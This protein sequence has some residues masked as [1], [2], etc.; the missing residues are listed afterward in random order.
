MPTINPRLP[1]NPGNIKMKCLIWEN[2][3]IAARV[4]QNEV[5]PLSSETLKA[6]PEYVR[7]TISSADGVQGVW[8]KEK[9][10]YHN[11]FL[12]VKD[13]KGNAQIGES[14][15]TDIQAYFD[16]SALP[17]LVPIDDETPH[18][19]WTLDGSLFWSDNVT[20]EEI[21]N[22]SDK[23]LD[24]K[25]SKWTHEVV[26]VPRNNTLGGLFHSAVNLVNNLLG[27]NS[28]TCTFPGG[29]SHV[30]TKLPDTQRFFPSQ[31]AASQAS[32][33]TSKDG[34][35]QQPKGIHWKVTKNTKLFQGE[36]FFVEFR[37]RAY[38]ADSINSKDKL[39]SKYDFLDSNVGTAGGLAGTFP[40]NAG[41]V[42]VD[43]DNQIIEESRA[44]FDFNAQPY[45]MIEMGQ[46]T[47]DHYFIILAHN[48][49]PR[50]VQVSDTV[51]V[52]AV[53]SSKGMTIAKP[54]FTCS[55]TLGIY[56]GVSSKDLMEKDVLRIQ[57]RQHLGS[58]VI[59]FSGYEGQPWVVSRHDPVIIVGRD[60]WSNDPKD[61]EE[62]PT[63]MLIAPSTI[64]LYGGNLKC[65][66]T[67]APL[68]YEQKAN[69]TLPQA[70]V[71]KGPLKKENINLRLCE[72]ATYPN[73]KD[74]KKKFVYYQDAEE[75]YETVNGKDDVKN[76]QFDVQ[77]QKVKTSGK[78]PDK[79]AAK[80]TSLANSAIYITPKTTL[81]AVGNAGAAGSLQMA[82]SFYGE[83]I[84]VAGD[85]EFPADPANGAKTKWTLKS[86]MTP[87]ATGWRLYVP[88]SKPTGMPPVVDVANHVV[89][90][91]DN[92]NA[93]D[94]NKIDHS[95]QI[96]FLITPEQTSVS[97]TTRDHS[98]YLA[99][100]H[101]K[102]FYI[103]IY[104]WWE[105]GFM[106]CLP[107]C[108]C[109]SCQGC[110]ENNVIFTGL[111]HGGVITTDSGKKTMEC[112]L[113]DY[114]KIL[115]DMVLIN[116]PFFDG[117]RDFNAVYLLIKMAGFVDG[118]EEAA[119]GTSGKT[120]DKFPP[121]A[122]IKALADSPNAEIALPW[123]TGGCVPAETINTWEFVLPSAYDILQS[124]NM[125]F[126]DGTKFEDAIVQI[127][128]KAGKC[129]YFD[130][131]GVFHYENLKEQQVTFLGADPLP[132]CE[133]HFYASPKDFPSELCN[134]MYQQ[135]R[136]N[137][138]YRANVSDVFN[139]IHVVSS[140][141]EG[142][143]VFADNPNWSS[144]YDPTTPGYIGYR[145][146]FYQQ[147]GLFG[148]LEAVQ[149]AVNYYS[150]FFKPPLSVSFG[151]FGNGRLRA[152]H[153]VSFSGLQID[154][155]ELNRQ[156]FRLNSVSNTIEP[157]SNDWSAKY[158]G[159]WQFFP[160][161]I[162]PV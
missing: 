63:P 98:E 143:P 158:E 26:S 153:L 100:L 15:R 124:P 134:N 147:N 3:P 80:N 120:V 122:L 12:T 27:N 48:A 17:N 93:Q 49:K 95:G 74:P 79:A 92:W 91:T 99:S 73:V 114:W 36:D 62:K 58:L 70:Y 127:A 2:Q 44:T 8:L 32:R 40:I 71:A 68:T 39:L 106:A 57:V 96:T 60:E 102:T 101:D 61:Y 86:C 45:Y 139:L 13:G 23:S 149:N 132:L 11:N 119:P 156:A 64:S 19:M 41:V 136:G 81:A 29:T 25:F 50:L 111:C 103:R 126:S 75:Y 51:P 138:N 42:D 24:P 9:I 85:Y 18:F 69:I 1:G 140:T 148:S 142:G 160:A 150:G 130:R 84:L 128:Q 65:A 4:D 105:D 6:L 76:R 146:L 141:P 21:I 123:P 112:Q 7:N 154:N 131:W 107:G 125:K 152:L 161:G 59:T 135:V 34:T 22:N 115:Q 77:P 56:D 104:A 117:M 72:Q 54:P 157:A 66:W 52:V 82:L 97:G 83:Y 118:T 67:F 43:K 110:T 20:P 133:M 87:V 31:T 47:D 162:Q 144:I 5:Y 46:G 159:E 33:W 37:R 109:R 16:C 116:S 151:S 90:F 108:D 28:T 94:L 10:V 38:T 88:G 55:R 35:V 121:A 30:V 89:G 155:T 53:D 78:A 113:L 14:M 145:K 129:V 137:Y